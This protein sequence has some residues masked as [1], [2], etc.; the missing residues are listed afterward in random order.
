MLSRPP[1]EL[2][3]QRKFSEH[4]AYAWKVDND[5]GWGLKNGL[6]FLYLYR[7]H[8]EIFYSSQVY[9][10]FAVSCGQ[11]IFLRPPLTWSL[12]PVFPRGKGQQVGKGRHCFK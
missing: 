10:F 2:R 4:S 3:W 11:N 6:S 5:K 12:A 7:I 8:G 1:M 9:W